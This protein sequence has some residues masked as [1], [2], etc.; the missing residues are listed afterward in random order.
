MTFALTPLAIIL[1]LISLAPTLKMK[2]PKSSPNQ[3]DLN[4]FYPAC[5][6]I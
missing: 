5:H 4:Q 3:T 6:K 1:G 2:P